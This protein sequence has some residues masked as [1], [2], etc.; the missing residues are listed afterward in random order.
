MIGPASRARVV[1]LTTV[2]D[3]D[4]V[5]IFV[6]QCRTLAAQGYDV[7]LVVA[8]GLGASERDGVRIVDIGR[9]PRGRLLRMGLLPWRAARAVRRLE[10]ALLHFHDPELL[11]L[12]AWFARRVAVVYDAHEDVPQ[13]ILAKYWL[14]HWIRPLVSRAFAAFEAAVARRLAAVVAANPPNVE[15]LRALGCAAVGVANYPLLAEFPAPVPGRREPATI[16]YVGGLTRARGI[17]QLV[18]SLALMPGVRLLLCGRFA[19]D[20]AEAACRSL[21]GWRQVEFLG[22][23]DRAG[24]QSVLA[25][26]QVGIVTLLPEPNYLVALP[27]KMFEYMAAGVPVVAS[28]IPLWQAIVDAHRCGRCVDPADPTAVA[29]A[30]QALLADPERERAGQRGRDAVL[31]T[32]HWEHEAQKLLVLYG[33][34]LGPQRA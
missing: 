24:V 22:H 16:A 3:R 18:E 23:L 19:S 1:H 28:S 32:Y 30:V 25:R 34:L 14:P 17:V 5:R 26:A 11:G 4:D 8:D 20:G 21:P 2:H 27:V 12:G 15:R 33:Q 10:P 13:Q 7:V 6:K 31:R 9:R 29:G